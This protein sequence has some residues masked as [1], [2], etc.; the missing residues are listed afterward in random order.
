MWRCKDFQDQG[1]SERWEIAKDKRF[2]FRC[3]GSDHEG[4]ACT[5]VRPSSINGCKRNHH[6]LLHGFAN[7][8][9]KDGREVSPR[10]GAPAHSHTSTSK[11]E[12][13]EAFSLPTVPV[14]AILDDGSNE[15]FLNEEVAGVLGL[16]ERY[17]TVTVTVLPSQS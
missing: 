7:G 11:Q 4:R 12:T 9:T 13:T 16:K 5:R 15:T 17:Q 2:C 6:H 10:E 14:N 3:L 1:V 8:N